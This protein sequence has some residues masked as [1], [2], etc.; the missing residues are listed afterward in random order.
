M[1]LSQN[2]VRRILL[3]RLIVRLDIL[4][5]KLQHLVLG[6]FPRIAQMA[7]YDGTIVGLDVITGLLGVLDPNLFRRA[8]DSTSSIREWISEMMMSD[9]QK[10]P[11]EGVK[12]ISFLD[13]AFQGRKSGSF[14]SGNIHGGDVLGIALPRG[15]QM[16]K[17]PVQLDRRLI[18]QLRDNNLAR[19]THVI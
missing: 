17:L 5:R 4:Y 14:R 2:F 16:S 9:P 12:V 10:V 18:P 6:P 1:T 3:Q 13:W 8:R 15:K 7:G 19:R 11:F